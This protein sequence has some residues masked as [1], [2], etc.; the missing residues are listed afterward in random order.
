[1]FG[2]FKARD[3]D[4]RFRVR[5]I[6]EDRFVVERKHYLDHLYWKPLDKDGSFLSLYTEEYCIFEEAENAAKKF[7][8]REILDEA[9]RKEREYYEKHGVKKEI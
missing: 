6:K 2:W 5:Q 8:N 3:C 9:V 7:K 4:Y 1:M